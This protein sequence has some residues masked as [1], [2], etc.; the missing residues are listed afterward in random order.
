MTHILVLVTVLA[1][2]AAIVMSATA[3]PKKETLELDTAETHHKGG[4]WGW[5]YSVGEKN[6]GDG[7][8]WSY[9]IGVGNG[10]D[11]WAWGH[12]GDEKRE[13]NGWGWDHRGDDKKEGNGWGWTLC[14]GKKGGHGWG[15]QDGYNC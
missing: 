12:G 3:L 14:H 15:W 1:C 8:G 6:V 4:G 11:G 5:S 9:S 13:G 2:F 10:G 7:W